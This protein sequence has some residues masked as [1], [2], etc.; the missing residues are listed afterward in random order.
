LSILAAE[1][2]GIYVF[3][4]FVLYGA[5]IAL[6]QHIGPSLAAPAAL[7][8]SALMLCASAAFGVGFRQLKAQPLA[9]RSWPRLRSSGIAIASAW[10]MWLMSPAA[11]LGASPTHVIEPT[12]AS[13]KSGITTVG[14]SAQATP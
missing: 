3:H 5:P 4:L 6:A 2:L 8:V 12:V 14:V 1:T 11:A 7:A 13:G 10:A 9:Q